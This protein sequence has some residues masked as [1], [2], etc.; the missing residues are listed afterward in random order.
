M[1]LVVCAV[2]VDLKVGKVGLSGIVIGPLV[3][4]V[5]IV[6]L[7]TVHGVVNHGDVVV[8]RRL[9]VGLVTN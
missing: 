7:V 6:G 3:V 8:Q 9:V 2:E 1:F 5:R 4:V